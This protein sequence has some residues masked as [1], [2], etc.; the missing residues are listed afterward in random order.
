[1]IIHTV[2]SGDSL[3]SIGKKYGVTIEQLIA[4][5]GDSVSPTLIIGQ[6]VIVPTPVEKLG[7]ITVNGYAYPFIDSSV[8]YRTLP[9]LSLIT[10]FS[11]GVNRDGTLVLLDDSA[12]I[13]AA[14]SAEVSPVL[15]I[16][17]L[18]S[19]GYF[20]SNTAAAV[21]GDTQLS[22]KL[23]DNIVQKL[24]SAAYFGV[25]IDFE[26]IPPEYRENYADF[27]RRLKEAVGDKKVLVAL[28]PKTSS[29]QRGLLY[30]AHDYALIGR[31]ADY[32]LIMTYEWGYTYGPPMAVAPLDKVEEVLR[33]AISV[34]PPEKILMGIPNYGYDWTL[35]YVQGRPARS[36]TND[37]AI[38]TAREKG[39]E[40]KFDTRSQTPYY[41]YYEGNTEHIVWFE[42]ARSLDAKLRLMNSLGLYGI[43]IWNVMSYF[44][45]LYTLTGMLFNKRQE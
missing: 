6:A 44:R 5:N 19:E 34:I 9:S 42:D 12:L 43:S 8:L 27:I 16:T 45:P 26:Y 13:S 4:A 29:V 10:P 3:Y 28:A 18:N 31:Y 36:I 11:Y 25:D 2:A 14:E 32:V 24:N 33:Y 30:E 37:T 22:N 23:I 41:N 17:T 7:D 38:S 35:P 39:A 40:I 20:D 21:L 15:L 1:M